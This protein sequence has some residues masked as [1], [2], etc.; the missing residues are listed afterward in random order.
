[1]SGYARFKTLRRDQHRHGRLACLIDVDLAKKQLHFNL[2][3]ARGLDAGFG[4]ASNAFVQ[5][6]VQLLPSTGGVQ[7]VYKSLVKDPLQVSNY[8]RFSQLH[9]FAPNPT[10]E[11]QFTF[12]LTDAWDSLPDFR[13]YVCIM[14]TEPVCSDGKQIH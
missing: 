4:D 5:V 3:E 9:R 8:K 11:E 12:D 13:L 2:L 10:F 6:R 1:M 7:K 14:A